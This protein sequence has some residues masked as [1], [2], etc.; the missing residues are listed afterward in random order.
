MHAD[1]L[2]ADPPLC[3]LQPSSWEIIHRVRTR[4]EEGIQAFFSADAGPNVKVFC[5][6]GEVPAMHA[7]LASIAGVEEIIVCRPG[8][9]TTLLDPTP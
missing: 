5:A 7:E 4:R 9:G 1:M 3:Y 8:H 6:P 2:A